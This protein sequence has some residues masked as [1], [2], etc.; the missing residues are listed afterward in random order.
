MGLG[1]ISLSLLV[2]SN[3]PFQVQESVQ[4]SNVYSQ[5]KKANLTRQALL[6][7]NQQDVSN[8][9]PAAFPSQGFKTS[10][11]HRG[12]SV[13]YYHKSQLVPNYPQLLHTRLCACLTKECC[14]PSA[15]M[16]Q[17]QVQEKRVEPGSESHRGLVACVQSASKFCSIRNYLFYKLQIQY[18]GNPRSRRGGFDIQN[19]RTGEYEDYGLHGMAS[20]H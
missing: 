2:F 12:Q 9:L 19:A 18:K 13:S 8:M 6:V 17:S 11:Q 15:D 1:V 3:F 5:R 16:T 14:Q 20:T 10:D 4:F 7:S